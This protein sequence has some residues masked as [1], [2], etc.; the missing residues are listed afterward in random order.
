M[1]TQARVPILGFA[2]YSGT[3]KTTLLVELLR[4]FRARGYR[5]GVVKHAHHSFDIDKPGK[6]SYELRHA[7]A[8]QMLIGSRRRWALVAETEDEH[9]PKLDELLRHLD[10]DVLDFVL[11]EGFKGEAFPKIELHRPHLGQPLL[12]P[13][14]AAII[15]VATDEPA[16]AG[17][18]LPVLDL[19]RPAD[20][21]DFVLRFLLPASSGA[22]A[23]RQAP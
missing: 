21:A 23:Y 18:R 6:D 9:E 12:H 16:T 13:G 2:A 14:D 4:I 7:G 3:G 8:R 11:V 17:T 10:Q 1:L 15:A 19:N 22:T 5:V 20:V